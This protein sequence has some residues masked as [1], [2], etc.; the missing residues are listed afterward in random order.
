M[1]FLILSI[2]CLVSVSYAF[3]PLQTPSS[4]A[5]SALNLFGGKKDGKD[6]SKP[7]GPGLLDQMALFK[8]AQEIQSKKAA[9]EKELGEV[10]FSG[11]SENE[12]VTASVKYVASKSPMDPQPEFSVEGFDFDDDWFN[13]ATPEDLSSAVV[14]AYRAGV[15][16]T[17]AESEKQFQ[18]LAKDLQEMMGGGAA[19]AEPSKE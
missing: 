13:D 1:K 12:K 17:Q 14:E 19:P 8:K 15:K 7:G 10:V 9:I 16:E 5:T 6:G 4:Q 11:K 2:A 3:C 18:S